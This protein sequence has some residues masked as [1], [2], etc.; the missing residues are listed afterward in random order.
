[1]TDM[2][3]GEGTDEWYLTEGKQ[4]PEEMQ[5]HYFDIGK[6]NRPHQI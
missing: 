5:I 6:R 2:P 4:G 1:M 3:C